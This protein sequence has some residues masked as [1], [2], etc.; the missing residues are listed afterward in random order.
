MGAERRRE[1]AT[2]AVMMVLVR[3]TEGSEGGLAGAGWQRRHAC[4]QRGRRFAGFCCLLLTMHGKRRNA[5]ATARPGHIRPLR[6]RIF[7]G[8]GLV[9]LLSP[10]RPITGLLASP[11]MVPIRKKVV[12]IGDG[13]CGKARWH[14]R[15]AGA[16]AAMAGVSS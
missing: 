7:S 5:H 16:P 15:G 4:R 11:R 12:V 3:M 14:V 9:R 1:K 8:F 10:R 13:A 2:F 6:C